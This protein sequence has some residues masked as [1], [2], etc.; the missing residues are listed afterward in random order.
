MPV[1]K[2]LEE[3]FSGFPTEKDMMRI[4]MHTS[5]SAWANDVEEGDIE[6]WLK[7]YKGE[8]FEVKHERLIALWL[9]SHFTF[10]NQSE[11]TQLCR[12]IY[13]D[14]VHRI[15][16]KN[17]AA[18]MQP[19]DL[20]ERFFRLANVIPSEE[21][22]GSGG[23]IAYFFRQ[24]ND[25]PM[26]LFN[27]S[28]DNVSDRI[29]NIIIID[30]VTLTS[31]EDGQMHRFFKKKDISKFNSESLPEEDR[32]N[33]YL[34]TLVSTT[35]SIEY[36]QNNFGVEVITAI[37]LD[38]RDKCFS[39]NSDVFSAYPDLLTFG[40]RFAEHYGKR[41]RRLKVGPLGYKDG[42]FTFGFFYNTPDNTLPIFWGEVDGWVP[43][44]RRF[45]KNYFD[46][47]FLRNER[48]I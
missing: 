14:L 39:P 34:L 16:T 47:K 17:T 6:N 27:F 25:L 32:K 15:V 29:K 38:S 7:N 1:K 36:L 42:Q 12:V 40:R 20:V 9:L 22:S 10:Y 46:R 8:V 41:F 45:H 11:V 13:N 31:G 44:M 43:I 37:R 24:V 23:F 5:S 26:S 19:V 48:F 35:D 33:V 4:I 18:A 3:I 28:I 30:D 2:T 21:I